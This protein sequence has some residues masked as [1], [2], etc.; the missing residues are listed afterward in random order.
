MTKKIKRISKNGPE[1]TFLRGDTFLTK[2][3]FFKN[4]AFG[5][6][7]GLHF[8]Y[9]KPRWSALAPCWIFEVLQ[10]AVAINFA[11]INATLG[12]IG[13]HVYGLSNANVLPFIFVHFR[14]VF[15]YISNWYVIAITGQ[16]AG[17]ATIQ[18][19]SLLRLPAMPD[20]SAMQ[21][22]KPARKSKRLAKWVGTSAEKILA[23]RGAQ[24]TA[25]RLRVSCST[26][27]A[28]RAYQHNYFQMILKGRWESLKI[29][30]IS[31]GA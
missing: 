25:L 4:V 20:T 10:L 6:W 30:L 13:H 8:Q 27:W 31:C 28:S 29:Q 19:Y 23:Q 21:D 7:L 9:E 11:R 1:S 15:P 3:S 12:D 17:T 26:D 18:M 5:C 2:K 22:G 16:S 14:G 24:P